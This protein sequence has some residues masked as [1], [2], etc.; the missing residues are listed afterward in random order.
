LV[1]YRSRPISFAISSITTDEP[2][3]VKRYGNSNRAAEGVLDDLSDGNDK[4]YDDGV[5]HSLLDGA[6]EGEALGRSKDDVDN[7][8]EGSLG[9]I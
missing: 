4:G 8:V 9:G 7:E 6:P 5:A 2:E 3:I 1:I